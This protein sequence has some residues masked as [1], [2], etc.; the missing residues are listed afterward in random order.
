MEINYVCKILSR[1]ILCLI[2]HWTGT[3]DV[4]FLLLTF[5]IPLGAL[6]MCP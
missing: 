3:K 4:G 2:P 5:T 6:D 1:A